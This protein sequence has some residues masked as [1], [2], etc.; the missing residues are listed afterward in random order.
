MKIKSA[1]VVLCVFCYSWIVTAACFAQKADEWAMANAMI[2][3][4]SPIEIR[5]GSSYDAR[6]MYPVPDGPLFP[7]KASV[8]WSIA[9]AVKGISIDAKTGKII[10][11]A[12]VPHGAI[13]TVHANVEN[14]RRALSAKLYVFRT[15][16]NPLVGQWH[17][18]THVAC[19]AAQ[20]IKIPAVRPHALHGNDWKFHVNQQFWVGKEMNIAAGVRLTG[21][22]E[23]DQKT[24]KIKLTPTWPKKST[25]TWSYLLRD[26]GKTLIL[27]PGENQD[28][29]EAGC[30]Y[31]L[32]LH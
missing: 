2:G 17:V 19:G 16:E 3:P 31:V 5:A 4:D 12:D 24:A 14:G 22:Y 9:P 23:L 18:D 26:D 1:R 13:T 29:L 27:Q 21:T 7:L 32:H 8:A 11:D 15:E 28:D 6:A 10:V 30:G 25:S 20:E